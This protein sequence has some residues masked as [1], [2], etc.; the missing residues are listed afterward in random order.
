MRNTKIKTR[1]KETKFKKRNVKQEE[2]PSW[3]SKRPKDSE[4][5]KPKTHKGKLWW[6]CLPETGGKCN[7]EY[8]RHKPLE[9][10]GTARMKEEKNLKDQKGPKPKRLKLAQAYKAIARK[11]EV[12]SDSSESSQDGYKS[13]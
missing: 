11:P 6:Y 2:K 8:R 5:H 12:K 3:M 7:G 4:L 13:S 10:K 1:P 9:S